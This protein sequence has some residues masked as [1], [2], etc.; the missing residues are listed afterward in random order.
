M[1]GS[2][3][4]D[5][6]RVERRIHPLPRELFDNTGPIIF[7]LPWECNGLDSSQSS[8]DLEDAVRRPTA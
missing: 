6:R 4:F 8:R 3:I 5:R 7:R 2:I 1:L